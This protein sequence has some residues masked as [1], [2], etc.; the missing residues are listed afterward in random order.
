MAIRIDN[1]RPALEKYDVEP[2]SPLR[3]AVH[4]LLGV[5]GFIGHLENAKTLHSK[6]KDQ[7]LTALNRLLHILNAVEQAIDPRKHNDILIY[8]IKFVATNVVDRAGAL[9][10]KHDI[11][12]EQ[13]LVTMDQ[14]QSCARKIRQVFSRDS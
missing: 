5:Q 11:A 12:G 1:I 9:L 7:A 10:Q 13:T 6:D 2:E 8:H 3:K 4:D 14:I